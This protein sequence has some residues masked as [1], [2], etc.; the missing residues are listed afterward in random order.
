M[1][2]SCFF[3]MLWLKF[4]TFS[5]HICS[6]VALIKFEVLH[7]VV[8][9][10]CQW[11]LMEVW[12]WCEKYPCGLNWAS[13]HAECAIDAHVIDNTWKPIIWAWL[14]IWRLGFWLESGKSERRFVA[15]PRL[16]AVLSWWVVFIRHSVIQNMESSFQTMH[17]FDSF[18][19]CL[20]RRCLFH[21]CKLCLSS[22]PK[23]L[24]TA[25]ITKVSLRKFHITKQQCHWLVK[26]SNHG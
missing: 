19:P 17:D 20:A 21:I 25:F 15:C 10:Q 12:G 13:C 6:F 11:P 14:P 16:F 9:S 5:H 18:T 3:C 2:E 26:I 23:V 1:C 22:V 8:S 7:Y 24:H 4:V